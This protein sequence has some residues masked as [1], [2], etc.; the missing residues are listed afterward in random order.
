V[1][2][3]PLA[4]LRDIHLPPPVSWWPPAPG[5]WLLALL[6]LALIAL[7]LLGWRR[8]RRRNAYRRAALAELG[9]LQRIED[10][11]AF[12]GAI[13]ALLKRTALTV[14]PP[15]R[16]AA[17]FGADWLAWLDSCLRRPCFTEPALRALGTCHQP[18][19]IPP[20]R[21]ALAR[22]AAHWIRRHRC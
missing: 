4:Q 8:H 15:E 6:L 18:D 17:L 16:V 12:A 14:A 19:H 21:E 2:G 22:A 10:P 13:N 11:A 7:A 1:N 5:W 9:R 20:P 3:D